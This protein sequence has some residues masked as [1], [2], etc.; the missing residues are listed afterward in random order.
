[1][2]VSR[3]DRLKQDLNKE[4]SKEDRFVFTGQ[5]HSL[6]ILSVVLHARCRWRDE[7]LMMSDSKPGGTYL[8][9]KVKNNH[10]EL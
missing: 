1:M 6:S 8:F 5:C 10:Q 4:R 3:Y 2:F 7:P 9:K